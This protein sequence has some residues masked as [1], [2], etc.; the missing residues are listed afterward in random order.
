[1]LEARVVARAARLVPGALV[2]LHRAARA[3]GHQREPRRGRKHAWRCGAAVGACG[4]IVALARRPQRLEAAAL[5]AGVVVGG[6]GRVRQARSC[7]SGM[8]MLPS[9]IFTGPAAFGLMSKSKIC[10]GSQSVAQ[11]LGTSTT[12]LMWPCTGAVPRIE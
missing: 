12:P 4:G 5:A 8:S 6:H 7:E 2:G 3:R 1:M 9:I 11:E 10:V